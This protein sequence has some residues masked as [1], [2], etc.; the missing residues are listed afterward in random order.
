MTLANT[1]ERAAATGETAVALPGV[2]AA[3]RRRPRPGRR[4]VVSYVLTVFLLI[5]LNFFLPRALPGDPIS[6]LMISD[7][8]TYV[9]NDA[10]RGELNEY[11]GLDRPLWVQYRE[12]LADLARGQLGV[13]I[14]HNVPVSDLVAE[15]LPWTLL[16]IAS[17]M[18][19]AVLLGWIGGVRS[20]WRRGTRS[21]RGLLVAFLTVHSFP[22]FFLGSL[23][24]FLFSV[25]L[26]W[27]PLSGAQTPFAAYTGP[28]DAA[29]DVAHHLALPALVLALQF[30]T[31]QFV[32]MRASMVGELGSGYLLGGRAKGLSERRL[33]YRYAA[34]NALLP[35]VTL[36]AVH[37]GMVVGTAAIL[38]EAVFGYQGMGSLT[39]ES[40]AYRDYPTLQACFLVLSVVVVT[41]NF[42]ADTVNARLDPRTRA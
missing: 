20:A 31:S 40:V 11:Y 36:T 41:A 6:A 14:R 2:D 39:A 30:T 32:E 26:G 19:P 9:Q 33:K 3:P 15:R 38:V 29:A 18:V 10:V 13:S 16:L 35:V 28:I 4:V 22:V 17:A 7:S 5:T 34:R 42:A 8:P 37:V 21:D 1:T 12:Y 27:F 25:R 24:L 23:A